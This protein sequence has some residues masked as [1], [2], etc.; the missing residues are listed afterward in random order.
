MFAILITQ[1][2]LPKILDEPNLTDFDI[3]SL[4]MFV[5]KNY[6]CFTG[7]VTKKGKFVPFIIL[8]QIFMKAFE[9]DEEKIKTTWD[10]IVRR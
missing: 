3:A 10:Q 9:Y 2:T 1:E 4:K 8:P 6:Y 7:Y 5:D